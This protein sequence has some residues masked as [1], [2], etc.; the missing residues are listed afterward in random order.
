[1]SNTR[2]IAPLKDIQLKRFSKPGSYADGRGLYFKV[3]PGGSK[4]WVFRY[5]IDGRR[6]RM[7]LGGYPEV[8]LAKAR[9]DRDYWREILKGSS[10]A[11]PQDPIEVKRELDAA[12]N[13]NKRKFV[14]FDQVAAKYIEA[15]RSSWS[16]PKHVQQWTNTLKSY[17]SP[18]IGELHIGDIDTDDILLVLEPIWNT[19][20]ETATRVRGRIEKVID[21]ARARKLRQAE[22]PARWRGHLDALLAKP[23]KVARVENFASLPH[24]QIGSFITALRARPSVSANALEFLILT[25]TRTGDV[26]CLLYTSPSPRDRQKSR[27]P[28]SA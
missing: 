2:T 15:N 18:V 3:D 16:N 25:N 7:G 21:Y 14:T 10:T 26:L 5:M 6:R 23:S 27:M 19:K 1:M 12:A 13:K 20:T 28:S 9:K 11:P 24:Q 22:N 17:A 8:G 4:S